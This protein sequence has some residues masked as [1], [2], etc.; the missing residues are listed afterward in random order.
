MGYRASKRHLGVVAALLCGVL[1]TSIGVSA[2]DVASLPPAGQRAVVSDRPDDGT[3]QFVD[4]EVRAIAEVGNSIVVGGTFTKV[5]PGIRGALGQV[6][7]TNGDF[8]AGLPDI[9]GAVYSVVED[10]GGGRFIAGD[11]TSV[12]GQPRTNLAHLLPDGSVDPAFLPQVNGPVRALVVT[13]G[14]LYLGGQFTNVNGAAAGNLAAI[15]PAGVV[16]WT[17]TVNG[18]VYALETNGSVLYVGGEYSSMNG[19]GAIR[20]LGAINLSDGLINAA[21]VPGIVNLTVRDLQLSGGSLWL[22]GEFTKINGI[23]RNRVGVVD[24]V[25]GALNPFATGANN[26]VNT[27]AIDTANST[28]YIGGSFSTV[29]TTARTGFAGV[30]TTT[31][32]VTSTSV[33]LT[34]SVDAVL[35]DGAGAAYIGGSLVVVPEK[36]NPRSLAKVVLATSV[37]TKVV[38]DSS[39]PLSLARL[40]RDGGGIRALTLSGSQLIVAG[41]FSDYGTISR[42]YLAAYDSVTKALRLDFAP[43]VDDA[44]RALDNAADGLA[45]YAGGDF[46]TINGVSA[47]RI[48]KISMANGQLVAGF[49][50]SMDAYVKEIVAHPDNQRV[51]VGGNFRFTNGIN[52]ERFVGVT[53]STGAV[54][55][56]YQ[57]DLTESTNDASEGGVRAMSLNSAG[58]RLAI[59]GNFRQAEGN[60]RPQATILDVAN[61][62]AASITAWSTSTYDRP[63]ASGRAGWMRDVAFAPDGNRLFVVTSG[64][65][66]YPACDVLNAFDS[67]AGGPTVPVWTA[68]PGDTIETVAATTDAVYI[69]GHFRVLDWEHQVDARF[70]LGAYDPADGKPLSWDPTA[71][72]FRG[73]LVLEAEPS[74]LYMGSDGTAAGSVAHGRT[75]RWSWT[76]TPIWMRRSISRHLMLAAGDTT[77]VTL[78]LNNNSNTAYVIT[79]IT[80]SISGA[81]V[82]LGSCAAATVAAN[83][84]YT[85]SFPQTVPPTAAGAVSK[86]STVVSGTIAGVPRQLS[87]RTGIRA[88]TNYIEPSVRTVV[89]PITAPFPSGAVSFA[90]NIMNESETQPLTISNLTSTVHSNLNGQGSCAVPQVVAPYSMYTCVYVGAMGGPIGSSVANRVTADLVQSGV[91]LVRNHTS[92]VL[93]SRPVDGGQALMVVGSIVPLASADIK[94]RD[95]LITLGFTPV[96]V[97]DDVVTTADT[98]GKAFGFIASSTVQATLGTKLTNTA[99]PLIVGDRVF[100]DEMGM[101]SAVGQG[102]ESVTAIDVVRPDHA[103]AASLVGNQAV[104]S[105]AR[106]ATW[107]EPATSADVIA[108]VTT[109]GGAKPTIFV[110]QPN[111]VMTSG[112]AAPACRIGL[113][114]ERTS[115]AKWGIGMFA[116]FDRAVRW[117][118][119]GCGSNIIATAAGNGSAIANFDGSNAMQTGFQ[120]P[121]GVV[122]DGQGGFY[123]AEF[124]GHRVRHVSAAGLVTTV[125]GTGTAGFSGEGQPAVFAQLRNPARVRRDPQ[126]RVVIVDSANHRI[127]RIEPDGTLTTIVGSGV[128]GNTGDG[129]SALAARLNSPQDVTFAADGTMY[130]ADRNNHKIRRVTPAGVIST[131]AGSGTSGYNGD[132]ITAVTARLF[133]PYGVTVVPEGVLIADFDN[134]RVRLVDAMGMIHTVAGTGNATAGGDGGPAILAD[135]HKPV[136]VIARPGGGFLICDY[137]NNR[138]R[139]V[140]DGII[141]TIVGVGSA[142]YTGEGDLALFARGNRFG[143]LDVDAAGNL[144]VVDRF[145]ARIRKVTKVF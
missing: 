90:I 79:G 34:G 15:T 53:A 24:A 43:A 132:E 86:P 84:A 134:N 97:D 3:I 144:Y 57:I 71:N 28:A 27:I 122:T 12:G 46:T 103:L 133:N 10:G 110:Y 141:T 82:G 76:P 105:S 36:P 135:V 91:P 45:V 19:N 44:V 59:I 4:G 50:T 9:V 143:A 81:V 66:Y 42:P 39:L 70:Q 129:G 80:D 121:F 123:V 145:N 33:S 38:P 118:A 30:S 49:T 35:L 131:F 138:V 119:Y 140:S 16:L 64:H 142:G 60:L 41:D 13:N 107:G 72:G 99:L 32:V 1:V 127:R 67:N 63:C 62:V 137:N 8:V 96:L 68:R 5:G 31:G 7:V 74:G 23:T 37:I 22:V 108:T 93:I 17:S 112:L 101:T 136:C 48:A 83:S 95:R 78:T 2:R 73:V 65:F 106:P 75:A 124:L 88:V 100:Y 11:F 113:P 87:D 20:R 85:C 111:D 77:T 116:F 89:G 92:N 120:D 114:A 69:G 128:A 14:N 26:R 40:P 56:G 126:G 25:T 98:A 51:F 55:P 54:I 58:T 115:L 102:A 139:A 18:V 47:Q 94:V 109:A 130:I 104:Y 29:G 125:A 52:T 6:D 61:P 21:F 117:S